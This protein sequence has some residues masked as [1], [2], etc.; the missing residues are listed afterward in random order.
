[1]VKLQV[2]MSPVFVGLQEVR[3][4]DEEKMD[5]VVKQHPVMKATRVMSFQES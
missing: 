2:G 1:M 3:P 4:L 5:P